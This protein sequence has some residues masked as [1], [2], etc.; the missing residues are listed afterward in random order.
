MC[1]GC[2]RK[3]GALC[4]ECMVKYL[5]ARTDPFEVNVHAERSLKKL[6]KIH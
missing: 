5:V 1:F 6:G 2:E 3:V 4:H